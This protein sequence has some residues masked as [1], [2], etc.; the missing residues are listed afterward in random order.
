MDKTMFIKKSGKEL[1]VAQVY[2]DDIIFGGQPHSIIASFIEQMK[3]KFE[4]SM[5]GEISFF[6]G[7]QI[8][9]CKS[10]IFISQEKY[11]RNLIKKFDLEKAKIKRT[12]AAT[13]LKV[14]KDSTGEEV[15]DSLYCS[16]I[17]SLLYLPISHPDITFVIGV[18]ARYQLWYSFDTTP[19]LAGYCNA[20]WV[21]CA[22][23]RKSTSDGCFF[24][25]YNLI[26]WF[27]KKQNCI[28][29]STTEAEYIAVG[30]SCTQLLWMKQ[31]LSEYDI[32]QDTMILYC[33]NMCSIK[34][35]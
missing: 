35:L 8:L 4:M 18:C 22:R 6:F 1:L 19:I 16:I 23:Y 28:S 25:G 9:Q 5:V 34:H 3:I 30:S 31:M 26:A 14:S 10:G 17:G 12:H 27:S 2:I 29:L 24:L 7:F 15:D 20:D 33:D 32:S 11:A 13:Q 21:G